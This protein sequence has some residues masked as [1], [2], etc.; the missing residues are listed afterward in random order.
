MKTTIENSTSDDIKRALFYSQIQ[1]SFYNNKE[2]GSTLDNIGKVLTV[3]NVSSS[4]RTYHQE[5]KQLIRMTYA[6]WISLASEEKHASYAKNA[7]NF[8]HLLLKIAACV[9]IANVNAFLMKEL[10]ILSD[11]PKI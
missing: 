5:Y 10:C 2:N 3:E 1:A 11:Y 8:F 9:E 4:H 7:H 6:Y